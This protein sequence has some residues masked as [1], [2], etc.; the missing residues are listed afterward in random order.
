MNYRVDIANMVF[1][2]NCLTVEQG[3]TVTWYWC[4][5]PAHSTTSDTG[6]WDSGLQAILYR[7]AH[8]FDRPGEY[9]YHCKAHP[10]M[11]GLVIVK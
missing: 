4:D 10:M 9:S 5:G 11:T 8:T 1:S 6:L 7:F 3:D 2:P